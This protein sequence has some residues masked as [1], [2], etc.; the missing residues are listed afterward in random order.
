MRIHADVHSPSLRQP[1]VP[2]SFLCYRCHWKL[3]EPEGKSGNPPV[4]GVPIPWCSQNDLVFLAEQ[5]IMKYIIGVPGITQCC[6]RHRFDVDPDPNFHV[7]A[8]PDPDWHQNDVD[9][10]AS[11][12]SYPKFFFTFSHN[13]ATFHCVSFSSVSIVSCF[14]YFGQHFEI[15]WKKSTLSTVFRIHDILGWIRI[16]GSMPLTNGSESGSW[17]R[18]LLFSSLTFKMPAKN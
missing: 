16:S 18:I 10:L 4:P 5:V 1:D 17:I 14:Q 9:P 8:G 15:F 6:D 12:G 13:I 2:G 11:C 3:P 7:D